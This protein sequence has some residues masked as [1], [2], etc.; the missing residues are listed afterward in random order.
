ME[1]RML[2]TTGEEV[3]RIGLGMSEIGQ[4]GHDAQNQIDEVL[5]TALDS[6]INFIDTAAAY[7]ISEEM[8]GQTIRHRRDE[9]ILATKCGQD[10]PGRYPWTAESVRMDIENSLRR[11]QTDHVDLLQL[12]SC[13]L[14]V[15]ERGDVIEVLMKARDEGKTRFVGYSGDNEEA[16]WAVDSGLF[17]TIQ[18]S[19]N[20]VDQKARYN[21]LASVQTARLGL[22]FKRSI[23]NGI[24]GNPLADRSSTKRYPIMRVRADA[25]AAES[26]IPDAPDDRIKLCMGFA[27]ARPEV[28]VVLIGTTNPAHLRDNIRMYDEELPI[29]VAV[30]EELY[31]RFDRVG[32]DWEQLI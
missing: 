23:S 24:F 21:L 10:D 6:G 32:S 5:N 19:Y 22:I 31:R 8:I 29:S 9:Y 15:L 12:H 3:S 26:S 20:V 28:D 11:L 30:V 7:G 2:G 4:L 25:M 27:F 1:R 13:D 14:D 16:Q 17:D 18:T